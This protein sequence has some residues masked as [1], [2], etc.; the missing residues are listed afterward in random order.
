MSALALQQTIEIAFRP[1]DDGVRRWRDLDIAEWLELANLRS[2]REVIQAN[3]AELE[4]HGSLS[5]LPTNP[6]EQ[7]G[8]PGNEYW[9]NFEQAMVMPL[10]RSGY[11]RMAGTGAS[12]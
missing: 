7:G 9:L 2:I 11:C 1:F 3:H 10:A 8:R 5:A 4:R 12:A 6:G